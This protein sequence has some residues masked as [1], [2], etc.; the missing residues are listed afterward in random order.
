MKILLIK[1]ASSSDQVQPPLGLG[2][3]AAACRK[4]DDVAIIDCIKERMNIDR[5]ADIFRSLNP[6]IVGF[7]CYTFDLKFVR[8][9]LE[10]CKKIK[11]GI[12][13][14]AGG[15]HPSAAP[16]ETFEYFDKYLDF[17]FSGEAEHGLPLLLD[18]LAGRRS[19][20]FREIP[21]LAWREGGSI[22]INAQSFINDLDALGMPAWDLISPEKYPES[23]HGAFFKKF[24]IAPIMVTRGCPFP[25]T[26]CAGNIISGKK[27]RKH[28]VDFML[29]QIKYLYDSH[30]IREFNIVDDNFTFDR[31]YVKKFLSE[32][33]DLNLD[34]SWATPNGVRIDTLDEELLELM[35]RSGLYLVSIGIESGSD[36]VLGLM[37]KNLTVRRIKDNINMVHRSGIDLAGF[38]ILGFPGETRED[39]EKTI[40]F[41]LDLGLVRANYNTYLPYPG[42]RSY[43]EL[44][45]SEKLKKIEWDKLNLLSSPYTPEGLPFRRLKWLQRSAFF[46]FYLRPK[47][48]FKN[49]RD[50]KSLRHFIFLLR[51][52]FNWI[53]IGRK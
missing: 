19:V 50:I 12:V 24:P 9:A 47:I 37:K 17:I 30:G 49:I 33:I 15:P 53:V 14:L 39:I 27:I 41:S 8:K 34:I 18:K 26:F 21:G 20:D 52:F 6:D 35:K 13:T 31:V 10:E 7:Q 22:Q 40:K 46:R 48:I 38:F 51:L 2:Y 29:K 42:T 16:E 44:V 36:R 1:P 25:C 28:S 43:E 11:K 3:L 23:Q 32:L 4:K 45:S 5:L